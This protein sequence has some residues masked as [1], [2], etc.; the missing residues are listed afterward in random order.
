MQ[1]NFYTGNKLQKALTCHG[2]VTRSNFTPTEY[3]H[4]M[5]D[6]QGRRIHLNPPGDSHQNCTQFGG[7]RN[8]GLIAKHPLSKFVRQ[9]KL[10]WGQLSN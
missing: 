8:G 5:G 9:L 4:S 2:V 10:R 7:E 3:S 1:Q 6:F